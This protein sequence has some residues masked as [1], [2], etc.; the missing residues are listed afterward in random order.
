MYP[1]LL[2]L[3]F[4]GVAILVGLEGGHDAVFKLTIKLG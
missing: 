4:S 1:Q 2:F 3:L